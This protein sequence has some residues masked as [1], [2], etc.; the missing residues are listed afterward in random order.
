M[1]FLDPKI[2]HILPCEVVALKVL[3]PIKDGNC[4]EIQRDPALSEE[5]CCQQFP[6]DCEMAANKVRL[7][8][9]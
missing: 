9:P 1:A 4:G 5:D 8:P 6:D 2:S 7:T 3:K